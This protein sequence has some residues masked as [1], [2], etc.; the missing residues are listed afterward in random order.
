MQSAQNEITL[1]VFSGRVL[2]ERATIHINSPF[3]FSVPLQ[4]GVPAGRLQIYLIASQASAIFSAKGVVENT[5]TL[6]NIVEDATRTVLDA[7]GYCHGLGYDLDIAQMICPERGQVQIFGIDV[8]AVGK[9]CEDLGVAWQQVMTALDTQQGVYLRHALAD[10]REATKSPKDT[11]F[12]CY[13]A[14]E[15]LKNGAVIQAGE[16]AAKSRK[17]SQD[18]QVFRETYSIEKEDILEIKKYA[19]PVRHGNAF[20]AVPLSDAERGHILSTAWKI[21]ATFVLAVTARLGGTDRPS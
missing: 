13:R 10:L 8:P 15:S 17:K 7:V 21:V 6:R 18:W 11:G 20:E 9:I 2:P 1:Y 12:F 16:R 19:D 5:F 4:D 14:V 3:E